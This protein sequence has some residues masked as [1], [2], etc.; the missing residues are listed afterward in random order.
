MPPTGMHPRYIDRFEVLLLD[1]VDTFMFG[2][3]RFSPTEDF[4]ATYRALGGAHLD[5]VAVRD[6]ILHAFDE[7][8]DAYHDPAQFCSFPTLRS[9]LRR[10]PTARPL[11]ETELDLLEAV[12]ARH[13]IGTIPDS[14]VETLRTLHQTHVLGL[15]SNIWARSDVFYEAF[16]QA[17]IR[18]LFDVIVFSSDHGIVKP[19]ADL[20]HAAIAVLDAPASAMVYVGDDPRCDVEGAV[21]AGLP[22]IWITDTPTADATAADRTVRDL[23][24]VLTLQ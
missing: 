24:E 11:P 7:L 5:D 17:G 14:Y 16:E 20:F 18:S 8:D 2:G 21:A 1:M 13:E 4:G 10:H 6:V 23:E 3:D 19:A 12:F 22:A 9:A 15:V